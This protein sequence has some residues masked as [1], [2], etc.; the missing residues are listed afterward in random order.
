MIRY[1]LSLLWG[2]LVRARLYLYSTSI[3][4]SYKSKIRVISLG[5]LSLGGAGKTPLAIFLIKELSKKGLKTVLVQK[6]Y[7]GK[8]AS[9]S[10]VFLE[11]NETKSLS[12]GDCGDEVQMV[13]RSMPKDGRLCVSSDKTRAVKEIEKKWPDTDIIIID[14]GFQHLKLKRDVNVLLMTSNKAFQDKLLPLGR[15]REGYSRGMARADIIVFTKSDF[16][17]KDER[18]KLSLKAK[19]YN[20]CAKIFFSTTDFVSSEDLSSR[21]VF[22]VSS[23]YD[24]EF[25]HIKLRQAG[26]IFERYMAFRDHYRFDT[27]TLGMIVESAKQNATKDIVLTS[28]DW[29]KI[30]PLKDS[31]EK[32]SRINFIESYYEHKIEDKERFIACFT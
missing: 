8:L 2:I 3:L 9:G 4:K 15:L 11:K 16:L 6:G 32:T 19:S 31:L 7:K 5:N 26:A 27:K 30:E 23:I 20:P 1:L 22:P 17:T 10:C 14:D 28:K 25:F 13:F 21:K 29:V 24:P 18:E 12:L